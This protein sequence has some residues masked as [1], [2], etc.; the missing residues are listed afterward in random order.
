M[1]EVIGHVSGFYLF[2]DSL[3]N[4]TIVFS[5]PAG[6]CINICLYI[7]HLHNS[8]SGCPNG[9]IIERH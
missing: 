3:V 5:M 7:M 6:V 1:N 4:G 8:G 2:N 9:G